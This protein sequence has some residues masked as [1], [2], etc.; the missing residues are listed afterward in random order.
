MSVKDDVLR[1]L[2][3]DIEA[4]IKSSADMPASFRM[5]RLEHYTALRN[6]LDM[7]PLNAPQM[8]VLSRCDNLLKIADEIYNRHIAPD[9]NQPDFT[10]LTYRLIDYVYREERMEKLWERLQGENESF[11]EEMLQKSPNEVYEKAYEI[12]IKNDLLMLFE[13]INISARKIDTLMSFDYPLYAMYRE[14]LDTDASHMDMLRDTVDNLIHEQ[15]KYLQRQDFII[16]G[17][18]PSED[19]SIWNA[20]YDGDNMRFTGNENEADEDL[21]Q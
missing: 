3:Q 17:E 21:E 6:G 8:D 5:K 14:W 15:D 20:M 13:E 1:K 2:D 11:R 9:D 7:M 4:F 18:T 12:T 19:I 10:E 16:Q